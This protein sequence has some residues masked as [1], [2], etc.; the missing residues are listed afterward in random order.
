MVSRSANALM[1]YFQR[2]LQC[3]SGLCW[4]FCMDLLTG[5][6]MHKVIDVKI[7]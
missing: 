5:L 6:P 3:H 1:V 2:P 7:H 4:S